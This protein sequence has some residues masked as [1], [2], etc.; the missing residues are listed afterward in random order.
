MRVSF[1]FHFITHFA[2]QLRNRYNTQWDRFY[3]YQ[4]LELSQFWRSPKTGFQ[5]T[6]MFEIWTW[7]GIS[8][9]VI[10]LNVANCSVLKIQQL[11]HVISENHIRMLPNR[12]LSAYRIVTQVIQDYSQRDSGWDKFLL[13]PRNS[14]VTW[15]F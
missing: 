6:C 7:K 13:Y 5:A 1:E 12:N 2:I 3:N 15:I 14:F 4:W 8:W 10:E 9:F 11:M